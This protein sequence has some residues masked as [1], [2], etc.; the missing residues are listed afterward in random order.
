MSSL[1]YIFLGLAILILIIEGPE[2]L[3]RLIFRKD[4]KKMVEKQKA[5]K[6]EINN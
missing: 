5:N 2:L 1:L 3:F 4:I 6:D